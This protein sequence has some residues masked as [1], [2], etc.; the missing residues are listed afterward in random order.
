M[1][2]DVWDEN[3]LRTLQ[4]IGSM[5]LSPGDRQEIIF[6]TFSAKV[7]RSECP[8]ISPLQQ[9]KD[10]IDLF[11]NDC[12]RGH[13]NASEANSP[14]KAIFLH[15]NPGHKLFLSGI[16]LKSTVRVFD[17]NG[18]LISDLGKAQNEPLIWQPTSDLAAGI[19]FVEVRND[20]FGK[21]VLKWVFTQ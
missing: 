10:R 3:D 2:S 11:F 1:C 19:Y 7:E 15:S 9:K 21:R 6:G 17:L 13:V 8:D 16:P 12:F 4:S 20:K 5:R 14:L 18:K